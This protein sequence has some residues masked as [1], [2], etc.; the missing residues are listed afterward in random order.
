MPRW[1]GRHSIMIKCAR[2]DFDRTVLS[3]D[4][5]SVLSGGAEGRSGYVKPGP[6]EARV[7]SYTPKLDMSTIPDEVLYAE[8]GRRRVAKRTED[9]GH[10]HPKVMRPCPH[11]GKEFGAR[12]LRTH[13]PHCSKRI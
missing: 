5:R 13:R 12:E 7:T 6:C 8:V 9:S 11:C 3:R 10:G 1:E 4:A 2:I